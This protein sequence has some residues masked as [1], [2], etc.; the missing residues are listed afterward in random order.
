MLQRKQTFIF[1]A[2]IYFINKSFVVSYQA[3]NW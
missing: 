1:F 2:K 3:L